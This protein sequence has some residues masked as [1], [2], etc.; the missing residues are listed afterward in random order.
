LI[1]ENGLNSALRTLGYPKEEVVSHGFRTSASTFL[2]ER[3]FNSDVIEA[4]LAH[5]EEDEVRRA[6]NRAKYWSQRVE[7]MQAWADLMDEFKLTKPTVVALS[8]S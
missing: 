4:C 7:L 2:N 6:Y 5:E 8:A 3:G 1:S